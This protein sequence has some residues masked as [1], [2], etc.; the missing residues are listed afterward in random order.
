MIHHLKAAMR[1]IDRHD[2]R[3][4]NH[5][6]VDEAYKHL[7]ANNAKMAAKKLDRYDD[8]EG[9]SPTLDQA[10]MHIQKYLGKV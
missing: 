10:R 2:N 9:R 1:K 8:L 3:E 5:P 6:L 7:A 4:G